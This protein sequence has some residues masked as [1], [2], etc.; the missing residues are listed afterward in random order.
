MCEMMFTF[1]YAKPKACCKN[2]GYANKL[3]HWGCN[4]SPAKRKKG[5]DIKMWGDL[6]CSPFSHLCGPW[7]T[8]KQGGLLPG[9][10]HSSDSS[11]LMSEQGGRRSWGIWTRCCIHDPADDPDFLNTWAIPSI[12]M[13]QCIKIKPKNEPISLPVMNSSSSRND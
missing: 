6:L 9:A 2:V 11:G 12:S 10:R 5:G 1:A 13:S 4:S 8:I 7:K 3:P